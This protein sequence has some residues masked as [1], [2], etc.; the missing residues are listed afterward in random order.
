MDAKSLI[1]DCAGASIHVFKM[2]TNMPVK[3]SLN[4]NYYAYTSADGSLKIWETNSGILKHEYTPSSH[5]SAT[6]TCI[7]WSPTALLEASFTSAQVAAVWAAILNKF[8][9][10]LRLLPQAR[11]ISWAGDRS[12]PSFNA[13]YSS[14]RVCFQNYNNV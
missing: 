14:K 13:G 7:S 10:R 5:L 6:C 2:A 12:W 3:F 9:V 8:A 1:F 11:Q 4:G